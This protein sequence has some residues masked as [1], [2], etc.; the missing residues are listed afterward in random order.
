VRSGRIILAGIALV[1]GVAIAAA[2]TGRFPELAQAWDWLSEKVGSPASSAAGD[3]G[4]AA[5]DA[6]VATADAGAQ[7]RQTAPLSSAQLGA[8]LV[9]GSFVNS[10]GAPETMKVVVKADVKMGRAVAVDVKTNPPD[11]AI[12]ACIDKATRDLRWDISPKT[13]HVTVTY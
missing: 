4:D 6:A 7:H 5:A 9:H 8:P 11:P 3:R 10:C 1:A 12:A 13:G 2:V